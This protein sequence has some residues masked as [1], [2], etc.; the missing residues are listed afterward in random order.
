MGMYQRDAQAAGIEIDTFSVPLRDVNR[1]VAD[2][3]EDG[4]FQEAHPKLRP[5]DLSVDGIFV[6]GLAQYPKPVEESIAQALA[7]AGRAATLLSY[8]F[9]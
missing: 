1:A 6:A 9:V 8:N 5:V 4:F 7:A 2:G 3:E